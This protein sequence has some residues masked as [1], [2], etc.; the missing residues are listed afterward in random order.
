VTDAIRHLIAAAQSRIHFAMRS[1][2]G[3]VME[4]VL[5]IGVIALPLVTFLSLFGTEVV[6][7]V[8]EH[9]PNIFEEAS[10]W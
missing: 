6:E 8:Q 2:H 5:I 3:G 9:A 10:S 1:E 4:Y 7:W